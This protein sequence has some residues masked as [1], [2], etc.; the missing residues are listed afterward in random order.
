MTL[1]IYWVNMCIIKKI[2]ITNRKLVTKFYLLV[3]Y[4]YRWNFFW[5]TY[6]QIYQ[7]I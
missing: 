4:H 2:Q 7:Q 6:W 5:S 1:Y 3:K